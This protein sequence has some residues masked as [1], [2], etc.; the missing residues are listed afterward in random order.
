MNRRNLILATAGLLASSRNAFAQKGQQ[1]QDVQISPT[2][3][4]LGGVGDTAICT[5]FNNGT[6]PTSSQIRIKSW[7]QNS[8][9]D[10]LSDTSDIVASPPFMT[11]QPNQRQ[12]VRV[13]NLSATP[14]AT[15]SAYRVLLNQLPSPGSLTGNGV[16]ILLAF[17]VPLFIAGA[18]AAPPL[19]QAQFVRGAGGVILRVQNSGDVHIRLADVA[20][21]TRGGATVMR[22]PGLVGYVLARSTKDLDTKL[23]NAPPVGGHFTISYNGVEKPLPVT[24]VPGN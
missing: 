17:S 18:D 1:G 9:Q 5:I 23:S 12:V 2:M 22:L 19:L 14:G 7:Q 16:Q 15:E 20:Y 3:L 8:G 13:A 24:L 11:V 4:A 6:Q 21:H 10:V